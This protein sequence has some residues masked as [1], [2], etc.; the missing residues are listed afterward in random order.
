MREEG[1]NTGRNVIQQVKQVL[2]NG[3]KVLHVRQ[4]AA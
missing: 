3:T 1:M 4:V 2:L